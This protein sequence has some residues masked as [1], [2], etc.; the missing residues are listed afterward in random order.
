MSSF[1][2]CADRVYRAAARHRTPS[3]FQNPPKVAS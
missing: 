2:C 1:S 3:V